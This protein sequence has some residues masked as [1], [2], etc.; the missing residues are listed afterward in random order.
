MRSN[1][2]KNVHFTTIS[3]W[4]TCFEDNSEHIS[5]TPKTV[6]NLRLIIQ[7][8]PDYKSCTVPNWNTKLR[9]I[10]F[11]QYFGK[12]TN[13]PTKQFLMNHDHNSRNEKRLRNPVAWDNN[14]SCKSWIY[15]LQSPLH[16]L[17]VTHIHTSQ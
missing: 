7:N 16:Y 10:P 3:Q 5:N 2:W 4:E 17:N 11:M 14:S 8:M 13:I 9:I 6:D 1:L 15:K 12:H